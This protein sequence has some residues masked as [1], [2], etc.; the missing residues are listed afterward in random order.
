MES[1]IVLISKKGKGVQ[2]ILSANFIED[3]VS[4]TTT[5]NSDLTKETTYANVNGFYNVSLEFGYNAKTRINTNAVLTYNFGLDS[6][7]SN[8]VNINNNILFNTKTTTVKPKVNAILN[9]K[10]VLEIAPS[11]N[12]RFTAAKFSTLDLQNQRFS[13]HNIRLKTVLFAIK[14]FEWRNDIDYFHNPKVVSNFQ[15]NT[16]LWN[17]TLDYSFLKNKVTAFIKIYDLLNQNT[18]VVRINNSNFIEDNLSS[19]LKRYFMFG[20]KWR[21][22]TFNSK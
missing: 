11:Y 9:W 12:V 14:D 19:V 22:D 17:T 6:R 3:L 7:V 18:S 16:L 8:T 5:V 13:Q 10:N 1:T 20:L 2:V 21:F 4:P 15:K